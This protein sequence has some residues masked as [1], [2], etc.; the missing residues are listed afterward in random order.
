[1]QPSADAM[2]RI[3]QAAWEFG[4]T[5]NGRGVTGVAFFSGYC[6]GFS[7]NDKCTYYFCMNGDTITGWCN[8]KYMTHRKQFLDEFAAFITA[9][10]G[11]VFP[12]KDA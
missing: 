10:T 2:K 11:I 4:R 7:T 5:P 9:K 6:A 3:D 1:M 12:N 8:Y